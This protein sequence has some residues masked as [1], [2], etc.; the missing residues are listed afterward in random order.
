LWAHR[1]YRYGLSKARYDELFL[2]QGGVCAICKKPPTKENTASHWRH[3]LAVDHDHVTK[4][5]RGLLC[6]KCNAM[7]GHSEDD[8]QRLLEAISYLKRYKGDGD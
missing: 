8:P 2:A 1:K 7:L 5:V 3:G 6:N 4:V